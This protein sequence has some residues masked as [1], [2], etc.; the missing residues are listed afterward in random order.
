MEAMEC[1]EVPGGIRVTVETSAPQRLARFVVGLGLAAKPLTP[2]LE[3]EVAALAQ[4]ALGSIGATKARV[5]THARVGKP[6]T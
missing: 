2:E 1:E 5:L 6:T 3:R 4:G